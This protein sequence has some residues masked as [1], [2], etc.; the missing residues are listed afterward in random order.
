MAPQARKG[1]FNVEWINVTY[2][3][4]WLTV[5]VVVL[6]LMLGGY[7]YWSSRMIPRDEAQGALDRASAS[8]TRA[9]GLPSDAGLVEMVHNAKVQ[10]DVGRAHFDRGSYGE[11]RIAAMRSEKLSA[12][13]VSIAEGKDTPT[14]QVQFSRIE[15]DV[16]VKRAGSFSWKSANSKMSLRAGDQVKTSSHGSAEVIYFDGT[17]T[18]VGPG[19]LL[20]IR[21]LYE[22]PV[23]KVRRVREKLT[24]GEVQASTQ[25]RNVSGSYHEVATEKV[26]ARSEEA[27][28][29]R[30]AYNK[31]QK[32]S[33]VDVFGGRVELASAGRKATVG[34]GE[35]MRANSEGQL[36]AKE[37]LPGVPRLLLPSDQR[38]F[39]FED[40]ETE[41]LTLSWESL[42]NIES[43]RLM[44]SDRPLFTEPLYDDQRDG[45][46]AVIAGLSPGAYHWRVAALS[47]GGVEG[48]FSST[49]RFRVS[50]QRIRDRTDNEPPRLQIQEFVQIGQ[51]V[52]VNGETD[53]DAKLWIDNSKV[54]VYED[55]SFNAVVKLRR[56]GL[57]RLLIV[58]QDPAGNETSLTRQAYVELF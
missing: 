20:E 46:K 52:I 56:E 49:R 5:I 32:T 50:S 1:T 51:M 14:R 22:D 4:V 47:R 33:V 11:A 36:M 18:R 27:G 9:T 25:K 7:W 30:V 48:P 21:D 57:N 29:F 26:T 45:T 42:P 55:G 8:L 43:Y 2:R 44:I 31:E 3:S 40:A 39:V 15:G 17:V 53:P 35:R 34:A 54:D 23:T 13:V 12:R 38:V 6:G 24:W 37:A 28:E 41:K 19:S 16:R 58:A 10:L